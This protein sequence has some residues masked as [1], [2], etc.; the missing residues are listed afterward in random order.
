VLGVPLESFLDPTRVAPGLEAL[1]ASAPVPLWEA[2]EQ[3]TGTTLPPPF[4]AHAWPGS[5][6]LV[7]A[8]RA[9]PALVAGQRVLDFACGGGL[10]GIV[11]A[12]L[13][14]R[15][16]CNDIDPLAL[17]VTRLN[18]R[19]NGVQVDLVRDDLVGTRGDWQAVLVG[20][21]F[22]E[23]PL[24][25]RVAGWLDELTFAGVVVLVGDPGRHFLPLERV[26]LHSTHT[27]SPSA[28]WDSVVDRP[29]R[30]WRWRPR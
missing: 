19:L 5:L 21:V 3:A 17:E 4:F 18:A 29:A 9:A 23:A 13:G 14:A 30:V 6:A 28:A 11:A 1:V 22:Y 25:A 24:A 12:Q 8:L 26:A 20:D 10:A 16:T 15:V 2:L 27:L 7:E